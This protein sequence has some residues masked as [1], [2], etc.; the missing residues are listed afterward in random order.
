MRISRYIN[1]CF[2]CP[3]VVSPTNQPIGG[4]PSRN[5]LSKAFCSVSALAQ[6]ESGGIQR[7]MS[8]VRVH[9]VAYPPL[10]LSCVDNLV[11]NIPKSKVASSQ[12]YVQVN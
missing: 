11:V 10:E 5:G 9:N 8:S 2:H 12:K 7:P 4:Y 3:W 1:G 6:L